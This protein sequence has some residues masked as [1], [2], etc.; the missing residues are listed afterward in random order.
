MSHALVIGA[1]GGIAQAIIERLVIL[2]NIEQVMTVSQ[3]ALPKTHP[4]QQHWVCDYQENNIA[5][6]VQS[7]SSMKGRFSHVF[8]C[9]GILH[10][11]RLQPERKLEDITE[12][13]LHEVFQANAVIPVLWLKNL[14]TLLK[15]HEDCRF[16]LLSAR[17]GSIEDNRLG[18]WYS[19]RASKSAL[20]MLVKNASIEYARRAKNVKLMAFH[21]GTTDTELSKPFQRGV[22]EG[23]LFQAGFVA[24]KLLSL[25]DQLE[26]DQKAEFRDWNHQSIP[27]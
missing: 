11:A 4:K 8:V 9:N 22:P 7:W 3:S 21:P 15:G 19:Y 14:V 23:K 17:V 6:L 5:E 25:M 18:G 12:A 16:T 2:D 13:S 1:S 27:W 10:N 26:M 24:E 20:N